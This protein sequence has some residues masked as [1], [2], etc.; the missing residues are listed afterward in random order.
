MRAIGVM[1]DSAG[2]VIGSGPLTTITSVQYRR[3]LDGVGQATVTV[4]ASDPRAVDNLALRGRLTLRRP[5]ANSSLTSM[6]TESIIVKLQTKDSANG[7]EI[8][9]N[10]LDKVSLLEDANTGV[11]LKFKNDTLDDVLTDLLALSTGFTHSFVD[12]G[13]STLTVTKRF[14]GVS[15]MD[16]MKEVLAV[17][18]LHWYA[19]GGTIYVTSGGDLQDGAL[20]NLVNMPASFADDSR[21]AIIQELRVDED[22][23]A[24]VTKIVPLGK[25][26]G[27]KALNLRLSTR[28]TPYTISSETVNG[29]VQYYISDASAV[30]A[31]GTIT[32]ILKYDD[33]APTEPGRQDKIEAA[34][35]LYDAAVI[36]LERR[37]QPITRYSATIRAPNTAY[38]TW[39]AP[40][41]GEKRRLIFK[42]RALTRDTGTG[43]IYLDVDDELWVTGVSET[44]NLEGY[45]AALEL[46]DYDVV[47]ENAAQKLVN[48]MK[49]MQAGA[50]LPDADTFYIATQ[51]TTDGTATMIFFIIMPEDSVMMVT[52]NVMG[53]RDD[54]T[55][56]LYAQFGGTY[57]RDGSGNVVLAGSSV[58]VAEDSA[59]APTITMGVF[60]SS[61]TFRAQVTVTGV[62]SQNW[63]W[64]ATYR[65]THLRD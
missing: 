55:A 7:A 32:E 42:G 5:Q 1:M 28:V 49:K 23:D 56:A 9:L 57:R 27:D 14:D 31:Y 10:L 45:S 61:P 16:A 48:G 13:L 38:G 8:V 29:R 11:A 18:G 47:P 30:T 37:K 65:V 54:D 34:N 35:Q 62:G 6:F 20:V 19:E 36:E 53:A 26:D 41:P 4:P 58:T 33:I 12:A 52:G 43:T 24:L 51:A 60:N 63:D 46:A 22:A 25:G 21:I 2:V 15:V 39:G 40:R 3:V 44:I 59:S 17:H 50:R 64:K